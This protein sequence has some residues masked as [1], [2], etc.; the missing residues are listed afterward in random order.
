MAATVRSIGHQ[1]AAIGL[2]SQIAFRLD[3]WDEVLAL[4]TK[5]RD[6]E[7]RYPRPRV[8]PTCFNVAMSASV[9]AMRGQLDQS[10]AYA[11]ESVGF[12]LSGTGARETWQRNQFY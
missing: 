1:T 11:Q 4:E 8:G 5:W 3:R 9:L 6:L 10:R 12:M 7:K 2:Q